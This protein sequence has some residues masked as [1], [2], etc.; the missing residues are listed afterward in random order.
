MN[1]FTFIG[2]L[3]IFYAF[4]N[5]KKAFILFLLFRLFLNQNINL[6]NIPG[7]PL[8][9]LESTLCF[10]F[11]CIFLVKRPTVRL[12]DNPF[13]LKYPFIAISLSYLISSIFGVAGIANSFTNL[14]KIVF[15]NYISIWLIWKVLTDKKDYIFFLKGLILFF[16]IAGLYG[17]FESITH[18]NPLMDYEIS[19]AGQGDKVLDFSYGEDNF[20]GYRIRSIFFHAIGAGINWGLFFLIIFY[21]YI[22]YKKIFPLNYKSAASIATLSLICLF[23]TNSRGPILFLLIGLIPL[24][25]LKNKRNILFFISAGIIFI[26]FYVY[27][28]NLFENVTSIFSYSAQQNVGG[29][30]LAMRLM[31]LNSALEIMQS[32]PILGIGLKGLSYYSNQ[33]LVDSLL[34]LESMWLSIIV[35]QGIVGIIVNLYLIYT[36]VFKLGIKQ[37]NRF[38]LFLSLAYFVVYSMTS[39]PGF[40]TSLLYTFIFMFIKTHQKKWSTNIK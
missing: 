33:T 32:H 24:F 3:F 23:F 20:R 27:K 10:L 13:P 38:V 37:H 11:W 4:I 35:Q 17:I 2:F 16:L 6:I 15:E 26:G 34:G 12:E 9:T 8:L 5:Y 28:V 14:L 29:S 19:I 7:V 1:I 40:V 30:N 25:K 31:Q 36:L 39:V 22:Y 18:T 21:I